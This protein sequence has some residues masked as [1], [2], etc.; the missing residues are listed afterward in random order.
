MTVENIQSFINY[1]NKKINT[2]WMLIP[3][4]VSSIETFLSILFLNTAD[5]L[6]VVTTGVIINVASFIL[7]FYIVK[8]KNYTMKMDLICSGIYVLELCFCSL[9]ISYIY[10][11]RAGL[12][13]TY[14]F[15]VL[16]IIYIIAILLSVLCYRA[17]I[18]LGCYQN[19]KV[20][21]NRKGTGWL[22]GGLTGTFLLLSRL[23]ENY[24]QK[25]SDWIT[26]VLI[27][28]CV[29]VFATM[30]GVRFI[31][32]YLYICQLEK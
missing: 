8:I 7:Y 3:A 5:K 24:S 18:A 15:F 27:I 29:I 6:F 19:R 25:L 23:L 31:L 26:G 9:F 32:K 10:L 17:A 13:N 22:A 2:D 11:S 14:V 16:V 12:N 1:G 30:I 21:A 4:I 20:Q 28:I